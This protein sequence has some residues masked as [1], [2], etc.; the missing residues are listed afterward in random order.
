MFLTTALASQ[1]RENNSFYLSASNFDQTGVVPMTG[2]NKSTFRFN[3][4]QK[5]GKLTVV[6]M[7]PIQ[8]RIR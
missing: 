1:A 7:Q 4:E 5:Y 8:S 3:G 2:Y 6:P